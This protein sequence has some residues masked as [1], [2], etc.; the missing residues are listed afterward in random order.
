MRIIR[1]YADGE[2]VCT[3]G[4]KGFI[5]MLIPLLSDTKVKVVSYN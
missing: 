4:F 2:F 1:I 3:S 5:E